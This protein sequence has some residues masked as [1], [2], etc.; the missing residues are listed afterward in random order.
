MKIKLIDGKEITVN[1]SY[2]ARL[3]E[4]GKAVLITEKEEEAVPEKT[5]EKPKKKKE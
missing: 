4:Q 3:Y 5:D 1:D 2:G